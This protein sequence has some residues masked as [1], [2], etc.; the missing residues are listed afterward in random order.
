M[1]HTETGDC[2][3][4]PEWVQRNQVREDVSREA[5]S[6]QDL[7]KLLPLEMEGVAAS[8]EQ[9][10]AGRCKGINFHLEPAE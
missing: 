4:F 6:E 8:Q 2:P 7:K 9:P 10:E 3:G 5:E 1:V